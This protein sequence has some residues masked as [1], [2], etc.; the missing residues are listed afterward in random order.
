MAQ[1]LFIKTTGIDGKTH[2]KA[3]YVI[4]SWQESGGAQIYL[5]ADGTYGYKDGSPIRTIRELDI[6]GDPHQRKIAESWWERTGERL[7]KKFYAAQ[8]QEIAKKQAEVQAVEGDV[9]DL[10]TVQ[11]RRRSI[12][13]RRKLAWCAPHTWYG[14]FPARPDWWGFASIIEIGT[15]RYQ[16]VEP[17]GDIEPEEEAH[18]EPDA[19]STKENTGDESQASTDTEEK[20]GDESQAATGKAKGD[21][22]GQGPF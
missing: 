15:F 12:A 22:K 19:E 16:F 20:T 1:K 8:D 9:S 13:D 10:D 14:W 7:S 5:H 2:L 4:R 21:K 17:T 18:K 11:Y 6:M 3:V